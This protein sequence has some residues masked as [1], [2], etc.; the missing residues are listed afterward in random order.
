MDNQ[1]GNQIATALTA[2]VITT[3]KVFLSKEA[4]LL[5]ETKYR[6]LKSG[7]SNYADWATK[8]CFIFIGS[9]ITLVAKV[10]SKIF[11]QETVIYDNGYK[12]WEVWVCALSLFAFIVLLIMNKCSKSE[13][14]ILIAAIDTHFTTQESIVNVQQ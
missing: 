3:P 1:G 8:I 13:K 9:L 7:M 14:K 6:T 5:D 10:L 4:Y 2:T 12:K 11:N